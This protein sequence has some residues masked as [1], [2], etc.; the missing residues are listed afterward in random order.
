MIGLLL[1]SGADKDVRNRAGLTAL[2]AIDERG[3]DYRA[4]VSEALKLQGWDPDLDHIEAERSQI[5]EML[6]STIEG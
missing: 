4:A 1:R 5:I 6:Q 3:D 2:E